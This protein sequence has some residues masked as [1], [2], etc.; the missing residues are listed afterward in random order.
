MYPANTKNR[1]IEVLD[2]VKS[3]LL[4]LSIVGALSPEEE[5]AEMY[6]ILTANFFLASG[7]PF[8]SVAIERID[9]E[10]DI[11]NRIVDAHR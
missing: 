9:G 5:D 7:M 1:C 8:D 6:A 4:N 2:S 3:E 11:L 10:I